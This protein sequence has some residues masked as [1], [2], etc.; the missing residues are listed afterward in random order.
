MSDKPKSPFVVNAFQTPNGYVDDV[1]PYL[2]G[3]EYKVLIY[4]TRRILGF[5][6]RQ[7]HISLSQFTDGTKNKEGEPLDKGTGLSV[8]TVKKCL[9]SLVDFGLMLRLQENNS[10]LNLGILWG[11]QWDED[12]VNWQALEERKNTAKKKHGKKM[13]K[14]RSMRHT[15]P[16]GIEEGGGNDIEDPSPND[17]ETQKTGKP[18]GKKVKEGA[19]ATPKTPKAN[20]FP[21]NVL[22]REVTERYPAKANWHTVLK[23]VSDVEARLG[24]APVRDDLFPFYEAWCSN[25]WRVDSIHWLEYAVKGILPTKGQPNYANRTPTPANS[26]QPAT[27]DPALIERINAARAARRPNV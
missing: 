11:L 15:P 23:F 13:A 12:K 20:D 9:A 5:Q 21:S 1:M 7:D 22:F 27:P 25:G 4:A 16:N 14:A 17:I 24:R 26:S 18:R 8:E 6:K 10:K 3:E 19:S 2:T